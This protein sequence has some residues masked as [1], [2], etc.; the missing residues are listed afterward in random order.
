MKTYKSIFLAVLGILMIVSCRTEEEISIDPPIENA[1][2]VSSNV[3]NLMSRT[4]SNDGS[5]D[6]IIDNANCLSIQ[7]P[8]TVTVNG[9]E[10]IINNNDGYEDIEN[11]ID[12]FDDD[13]DSVIISYP[14]TVVLTDF[15]TVQVNS[16]SELAVLAA[17]CLGDN[18]NDDDIE[19]IDFQYPISASIFND[20][21]DLI[22]T[23]TIND[24]NEMYNFIEDLDQYVAVSVSFPITVILADGSQLVI[25]SIQELEN[26]IEAAD[27]T[28]DEDDDNDFDDDDCDSCTTNEL[29]TF[30]NTCMNWTVD[31]L[32]R[33]DNDLEDLYVGY[34]FSFAS[35]GTINV[36][37]G[38][39]TFTGTWQASGSGNNISVA[40]NVSGLNDFNDTWNLHEV[41]QEP[42][43]VK[44]DLRLGDDRLRFESNCGTTG[45]DN[46]SAILTSANSLWFVSSYLDDGVDDT[47]SFNGFTFTFYSSGTAEA[48][49][50]STMVN[51]TWASLNNGVELVLNFGATV[52]LD[53]LNDEWDVVSITSNQIELQD[54]SGGGG[55]TDTLILT[56]Q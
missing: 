5:N 15:S 53:E 32:E 16:D 12:L 49:N 47:A 44:I 1:I 43:E 51:G 4:A 31:K 24:D 18:I 13:V 2:A 26:A 25:N 23:I 33:N 11:I 29:E 50:G 45:G 35:N 55:G 54:M 17:N 48:L 14:I 34:A 6:N 36:S 52:P 21:N 38:T 40:I 28:C 46:L 8:V 37:Q 56:K 27:D 42:G 30:F 7:L 19:C 41:E 3:S 39:N 10:L 20:N 9:T 22:N